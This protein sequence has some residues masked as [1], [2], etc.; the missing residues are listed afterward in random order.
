MHI[1]YIV[2]HLT[3][4]LNHSA[5]D[6]LDLNALRNKIKDNNNQIKSAIVDTIQTIIE[7]I[8]RIKHLDVEKYED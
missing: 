1:E 6:I 7:D 5:S 4:D 2:T 3:T 8:M